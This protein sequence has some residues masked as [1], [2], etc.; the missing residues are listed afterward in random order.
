MIELGIRYSIIIILLC[1]LILYCYSPSSTVSAPDLG[2]DYYRKHDTAIS[3]VDPGEMK[4][5]P[6][7]VGS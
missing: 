4:G 5:E 7:K 3:G 1:V 2:G 6:M